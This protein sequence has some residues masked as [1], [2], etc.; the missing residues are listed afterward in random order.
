MKR[1][2]TIALAMLTLSVAIPAIAQA[3]T[4]TEAAT[5]AVKEAHSLASCGQGGWRC[6]G[7]L[8]NLLGPQGGSIQWVAGVIVYRDGHGNETCYVSME[9]GPYGGIHNPHISCGP[10]GGQG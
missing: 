6:T 10:S 2:L 7:T 8:W 4:R 3:I 5:I 9:I 1:L